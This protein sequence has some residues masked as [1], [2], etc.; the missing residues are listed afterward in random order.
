MNAPSKQPDPADAAARGIRIPPQPQVLVELVQLLADDDYD[1]REVAGVIAKDPGLS[2]MVFKIVRSPVFYRGRA[3]PDTLEQSVIRLGFQQT[4]N[5]ARAVALSTSIGQETRP[6]Y[7]K[8]WQRSRELAQL[9]SLVAAERVSVCNIFP[10]QAYMAGVF[11]DCGVPVLMQRF[12]DYCKTLLLDGRLDFPSLREEDQRFNVDHC[13]IGY[14]VARHWHLPEFIAQA[15]LHHDTVP[16]DELGAVRSLV[17]I[18]HL[19]AHARMNMLKVYDYNWDRIGGEVLAELGLHPDDLPGY[20]ADLR[21]RFE[22]V[23]V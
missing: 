16:H 19:A 17:A 18:V 10:D 9:A 11:F 21:E 8:F 5:I 23:P 12:P 1:S 15:I 3:A 13:S 20:L 7:E 14:L 22:F 6:A 2:A 4:L